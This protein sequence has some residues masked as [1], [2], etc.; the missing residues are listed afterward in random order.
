MSSN[1]EFEY[2]HQVLSKGMNGPL[3]YYRT[4]KL[5]HDEENGA[6]ISPFYASQR[7]DPQYD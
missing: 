6:Y 5:R 7:N 2:Y 1:Q 3:N 4:S